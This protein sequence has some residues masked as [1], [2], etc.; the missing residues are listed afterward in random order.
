MIYRMPR[1]HRGLCN[2]NGLG[3]LHNPCSTQAHR[4]GP[5]ENDGI[6]ALLRHYCEKVWWLCC[7]QPVIV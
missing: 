5:L 1:I 7:N 3:S 6:F 2:L 4:L